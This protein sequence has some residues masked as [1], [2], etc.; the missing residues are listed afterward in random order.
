MKKLVMWILEYDFII[1]WV[2]KLL[3]S[4]L[5]KTVV[6]NKMT[7][8]GIRLIQLIDVFNLTLAS[9]WAKETKNDIDDELVTEVEIYVQTLAS[10]HGFKRHKLG[11]L[12]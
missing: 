5:D 12:S 4:W 11:E 10:R 8:K 1:R 3:F 7:T 6:K 9:V 2:M